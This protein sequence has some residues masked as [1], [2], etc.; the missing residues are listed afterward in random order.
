M[1]KLAGHQKKCFA[2]PID[3]TGV[4]QLITNNLIPF[5]IT[6]DLPRATKFFEVTAAADTPM[7]CITF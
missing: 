1:L 3:Y 5:K 4:P 2:S 7:S 6:T